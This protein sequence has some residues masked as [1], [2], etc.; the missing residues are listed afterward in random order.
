MGCKT[1]RDEN[2]VVAIVCSRERRT[3]C[4]ECGRNR[5][6]VLCD[7]PLAGS[8]KGKTCDRKLCRS[9]AVKQPGRDRD[10]CPAHA[11]ATP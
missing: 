11:R 10:F 3:W 5:T 4:Q 7:F 1:H 8:K 6:E 9:C 2:G